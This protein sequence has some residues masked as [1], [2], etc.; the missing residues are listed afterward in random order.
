MATTIGNSPTIRKVRI[1]ANFER[2][3]F[4]FMRLSGVV[5]LI[6]AVGHV[7][8]Q[9]ILNDVHS[10]S[11]AYVQ[12]AWTSWGRRIMDMLLLFFALTHGVN[13][14]R[15][16]LSDFVHDEKKMKLISTLLLVFVIVTIAVAGF[17]IASHDP[18]AAQS[19][20]E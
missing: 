7:T 2:T 16:I 9:L 10:L 8:L 15:N 19:L 1:K 17:A 4:L 18:N 13:G 3:A 20:L 5:L 6:L 11:L 14:L 12:T